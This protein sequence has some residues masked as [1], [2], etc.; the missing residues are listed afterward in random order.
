M[1]VSLLV[2]LAVG[3]EVPPIPEG[4]IV[5]DERPTA[6]P[7][8]TVV[9]NASDDLREAPPE[10][11]AEAEAEP[12]TTTAPAPPPTAPAPSVLVIPPPTQTGPSFFDDGQAG[13]YLAWYGAE[14]AAVGLVV[15]LYFA[16]VHE[17]IQPAPALIG[18]Q[19]NL[20]NPDLQALF[21]PR[22]DDVIG[23]PL[24]K[25]QVP[26]SA[27]IVGAGAAILTTTAIDL[28]LTGD[29]HRTNALVLGGLETLLGTWVLTEVTK[30]SFGR[31]RPDFR[32][33]Y[34][35]AACGG[36]VN[37]PSALDCSGFDGSSRVSA[38]SLR[39][40]MKSFASGHAS[41]SFAMATWSS[42]WLGSTLVW[43]NDVPAW[44]PAVGTL[45]IGGMM[46]TAGYVSATR[47]SDNKH[48]PEDVAV[49]AALGVTVATSVWLMH[50]DLDGKARRRSFTV[51]PTAG[52][53][54]DG[55]GSGLALVGRL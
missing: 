22:L 10:A 27:L 31:L 15:G 23:R 55:T 24:L 28:T 20:N 5:A 29:L 33:R 14:Y 30:L 49:G 40:G 44:G 36:A 12:A 53:G 52:L 51:V 3:A 4:A 18:P 32:E 46:A 8:I 34:V 19:F 47:I 37:T 42:L 26:T 38:E 43:G 13:H 21:D 1:L 54:T 50:F 41:S 17:L 45:G 6:P 2:A 35:S 7:T 25:E 9:D 11:E 48:H 16:D 39:D